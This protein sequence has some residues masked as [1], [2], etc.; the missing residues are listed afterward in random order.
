MLL[1]AEVTYVDIKV[2]LS[3][4]G[5][6]RTRVFRN[7]ESLCH[8][9][10]FNLDRRGAHRRYTIYLH[11][12]Q[13]ALVSSSFARE[14]PSTCT[15]WGSTPHPSL[16][17]CCYTQ[18]STWFSRQSVL[19]FATLC[20]DALA[21]TV[22]SYVCLSLWPRQGLKSSSELTHQNTPVSFFFCRM[23]S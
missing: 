9:Y 11:R 22:W 6:N 20:L 18:S 7:Y 3:T 5:E 2:K 1:R 12:P 23:K 21:R 16:S 17:L 14:I 19:S 10:H 8:L 13:R 4:V 15:S